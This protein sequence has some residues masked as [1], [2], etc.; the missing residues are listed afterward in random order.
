MNC[1]QAKAR[2]S[3]DGRAIMDKMVQWVRR[4]KVLIQTLCSSYYHGQGQA[5]RWKNAGRRSPG[6]VQQANF[7]STSTNIR[8]W[9]YMGC[10]YH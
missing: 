5:E 9:R 8:R 10:Q 6:S 1:D 7:I 4:S 2:R 3:D